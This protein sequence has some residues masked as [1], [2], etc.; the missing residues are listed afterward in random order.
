M[1]EQPKTKTDAEAEIWNAIAS[2]E[3]I[4]EV[5]P[6]DRLS[7]ETLADAYEK[8]GDHTR[9]L[10]YYIRLANV[11]IEEQ[12][13]DGARDLLR[14]LQQFPIQDDSVKNII[15]RIKALKPEKVMAVVI[16]DEV[17]TS[18]KR[19]DISSEISFAWNLLQAKKI[20]QDDY[21]KVVHDL[22]ENSARI[23]DIPV[24]TLHVLHDMHYP[25]INEIFSFLVAECKTPFIVMSNFEIQPD[26]LKALPLDFVIKRGAIVFESMAKD[27][28]VGV[29]NPYD[30]SL[31]SDIEYITGKKCHLFLVAPEDF[32]AVLGK[33]KALLSE[34]TQNKQK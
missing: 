19:P 16:D 18:P 28:L 22:S 23:T 9:A 34:Q 14:K 3:K 8:I 25:A 17:A 33:I 12:D 4:L 32:D 1:A 5:L 11:L 31:A 27:V 26:N 13:E 21:A 6:N 29:L 7:L 24:S 2:F 15:A 20:T 10:E 30:T